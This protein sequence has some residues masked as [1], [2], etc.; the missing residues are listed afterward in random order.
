MAHRL[1]TAVAIYESY[2]EADDGVL[3]V[4]WVANRAT[5]KSSQQQANFIRMLSL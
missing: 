2:W 5:L 3:V 1:N 4:D